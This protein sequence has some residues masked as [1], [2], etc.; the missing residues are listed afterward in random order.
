MGSSSVESGT[1]GR[2]RRAILSAAAEVLARDRAATLADIARAAEIGR[3][4]LHRY[5]PDRDVLLRAAVADA[6]LVIR[7]AVQDAAV[8]E[9]TPSDAVRRL[10]TALV[11]TGDRLLFLYG[12]PRALAELDP[13]EEPD[14]VDRM[15]TGL[16]ERG[17]AEGVF[18]PTAPVEWLRDILWALVYAGCESSRR[19]V[20]PRHGVADAVVRVLENGIRGQS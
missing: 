10:A 5:F 19:G 9:G 6:H 7:Q 1:R 14:S 15:V 13:G 17:Q 11:G 3:S 4:T 18:D 2:T 12:D 16:I 8:D 20:L